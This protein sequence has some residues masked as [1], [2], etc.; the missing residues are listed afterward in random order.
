MSEE[1]SQS[2]DGGDSF[3]ARVLAEFANLNGRM[4]SFDSRMTSFETLMESFKGR[5]A[6]LEEKVDAR[7][8]DTRPIWESV[9]SRLEN[10]DSKLEHMDSKFDVI[11]SELLDLRGEVNLLKKRVPPAA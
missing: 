7:L 1:P 9:L 10:V 6:S 3:E 8:H 2:L 4:T 11:A 5:L